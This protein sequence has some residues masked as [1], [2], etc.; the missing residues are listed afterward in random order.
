L[1]WS[2]EKQFTTGGFN[3]GLWCINLTLAP[4]GSRMNKQVQVFLVKYLQVTS[5]PQ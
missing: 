1:E 4:T 2:V 3:Q 5:K